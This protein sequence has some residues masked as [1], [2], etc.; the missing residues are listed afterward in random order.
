MPVSTTSFGDYYFDDYDYGDVTFPSESVDQQVINKF[1]GVSNSTDT[2]TGKPLPNPHAVNVNVVNGSGI[3]EQATQTTSALQ[4]LGFN[5][6][7][8]PSTTPPLS[9]EA[10]E[11]VVAYAGQST[12][13]DAEAVA[14]QLTGAVILSQDSK[15]VTSGSE[16]TVITGTN[17]S[18]NSPP[19]TSSGSTT[20]SNSS[21][22]S[23]SS[24][25]TSSSSEL[26]APNAASQPLS[27]WDPRACTANQPVIDN[28]KV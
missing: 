3:S 14:R 6:V 23:E 13:A 7:G 5:M 1:L 17:L 24:Q 15:L 25:A 26:A 10:L 27:A 19:S 9:N 22:S 4:S 18:V 16:V 20:S 2:M 8:T 21:N 12:E 28:P 11:T